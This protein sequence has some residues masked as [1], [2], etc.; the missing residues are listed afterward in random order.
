MNVV[1]GRCRA[2]PHRHSPHLRYQGGLSSIELEEELS[3][4]SPPAEPRLLLAEKRK[5]V[6]AWFDRCFSSFTQDGIKYVRCKK[7][8]FISLSKTP[9]IDFLACLVKGDPC[10]PQ[11]GVLIGALV[12]RKAIEMK[13]GCIVASLVFQ[14]IIPVIV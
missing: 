4:L 8:G 7:G 5:C 2:P 13:N 9:L 14:V 11:V 6:M 3:S 1:Y 12:R 10:S